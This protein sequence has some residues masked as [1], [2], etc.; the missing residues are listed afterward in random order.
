MRHKDSRIAQLRYVPMFSTCTDKDLA[1]VARLAEELPVP[2]GE[3]LVQE[4]RL[5][6]EF[7]IVVEGKAEVTRNGEVLAVLGSGEHFGELALLDPHTR[8]ATV[9]MVEDGMVLELSQR[10]FWQLLQDVPQLALKLL[11][12]M[13]RR[14]HQAQS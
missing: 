6:H 3:V 11:Q 1:Q 2:S 9:T 7:Y 10:E 5:G 14:Q 4:G 12:G 13:A 8:T